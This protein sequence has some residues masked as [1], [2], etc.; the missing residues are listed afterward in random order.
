MQMPLN[1]DIQ[2]PQPRT[3]RSETGEHRANI[4]ILL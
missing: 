2:K 4:T 3:H 1:K